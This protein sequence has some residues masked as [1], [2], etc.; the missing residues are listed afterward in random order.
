MAKILIVDD[1]DEIRA[2][3]EE[4]LQEEGHTVALAHNGREALDILK[5]EGKWLVLLDM[6]MP[7]L[8][9]LEV[10]RRLEDTPKLAKGTKIIAMSAGWTT[11][12]KATRP[13]SPLVV[14]N[15]P[16]PFDLEELLALITFTQQHS[17]F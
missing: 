15:I 14:A 7:E 10:I 16:K 2:V 3:L 6:L 13:V 12:T 11:A 8:S 4:A 5:G 1:D 9:G 17:R